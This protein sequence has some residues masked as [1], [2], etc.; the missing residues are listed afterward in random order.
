MLI[1][2]TKNL[3]RGGGGN[4]PVCSRACR[5]EYIDDDEDRVRNDPVRSFTLVESFAERS[6]SVGIVLGTKTLGKPE[7]VSA[8]ARGYIFEV[9]T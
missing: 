4:R 7:I 6:D 3:S 5:Y 8:I 1:E 9:L 2:E